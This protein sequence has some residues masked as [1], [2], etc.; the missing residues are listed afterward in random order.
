[1]KKFL[2]A[3]DHEDHE[4]YILHRE[5]PACLIQVIQTTPVTFWIVDLY[6]DIEEDDL[7]KHAFL[8]D[9]REFWKQKITDGLDK[10]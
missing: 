8:K 5:F 1:M 6:D 10:S 9:A 3:V 4:L 7:L 2:L